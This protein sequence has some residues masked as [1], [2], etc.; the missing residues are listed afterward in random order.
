MQHMVLQVH[1]PGLKKEKDIQCWLF[2][3]SPTGT[4][5]FDKI[6]SIFSYVL[7]RLVWTLPLA[8]EPT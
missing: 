8:W 5:L 6:F 1:E 3:F 4:F 7:Y 2:L